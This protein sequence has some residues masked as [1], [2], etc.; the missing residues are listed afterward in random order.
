MSFE[1]GQV[2]KRSDCGRE[3]SLYMHQFPAER[4]SLCGTELEQ[5]LSDMSFEFCALCIAIL[6]VLEKLSFEISCNEKVHKGD[7]PP[8]S[9]PD[10]GDWH[11]VLRHL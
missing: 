7:P 10:G 9:V 6:D 8:P 1:R 2:Q 11:P 4:P 3:A 5:R